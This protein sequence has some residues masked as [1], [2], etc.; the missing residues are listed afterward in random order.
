MA[1]RARKVKPRSAL[2]APFSFLLICAALVFGMSV[3]FRVNN[4]VVEGNALYTPQEIIEASGVEQG[5]NLFFI[6]RGAAT[7]RIY[8]RLPYVETAVIT[9]SLPNRLTIRVTE[10][11]A[12]AWITAEDGDWII[13]RTGKLL[14]RV[15]ETEQRRGL[16]KIIGLTP[17]EPEIGEIIAPEE[18]DS[19]KVTYL[20]AIL[21]LIGDFGMRENITYLDMTNVA[22]PT[23]DYLG[24]FTVKLGSNE[25]VEYKFQVLLSTV[26]ALKDGDRGTLDLS[27]DKRAH[28]T[29]D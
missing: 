6:N 2:F 19:P 21:R 12:I 24:R 10:S 13:D 20:T 17:V 7:N 11:S 8:S 1:D 23:F 3:F 14:S 28:F 22:N 5:D 26:A 27:I 16:V 4:I 15:E 18:A 9:R 25:N 29:Y